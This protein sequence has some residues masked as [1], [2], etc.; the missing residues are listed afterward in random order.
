MNVL[1]SELEFGSYLTYSPWGTSELEKQSRNIRAC[2]KSEGFIGKPPQEVSQY[3]TKRLHDS[4][5]KMPFKDFFASEVSLVPV[6]KSSLM[7]PNSL[8]VPERIAKAMSVQGFGEYYPCLSRVK[9]VPK[10]SF[11]LPSDRPTSLDHFNSIACK[12]LLHKPKNIVLVDDIITRGATLI[13]CANRLK[14]IFPNVPIK[15]FA[16]M[17]AMSGSSK[18]VKIAD[19]CRG[20]IKDYDHG[21]FREP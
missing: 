20:L 9:A 4:L 19:P 17:R 16:V 21:T 14:T 18:F 13:G 2:L 3:V 5:Y 11:S 6:P 7:T 1:L 8:W 12:I 15:G 10:A